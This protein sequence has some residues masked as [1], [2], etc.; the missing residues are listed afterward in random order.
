MVYVQVPLIPICLSPF[1]VHYVLL[2]GNGS[3]EPNELK[4]VLQSCMEDGSLRLSEEALDTMTMLLFEKA[5][6]NGNG[7]I[8]FEELRGELNK[9]PD[10]LENLTIR[11]VLNRPHLYIG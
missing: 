1:S 9:Y 11:F 6:V 2:A 10:I 7:R 3:I 4:T 8:T 5:D